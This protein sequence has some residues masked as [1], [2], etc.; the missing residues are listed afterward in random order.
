[1]R[2]TK[3]IREYIEAEVAKRLEAKYADEAAEAQRQETLHSAFCEGAAHAAE[4]AYHRYCAEHFSEVADFCD[5][6]NDNYSTPN[7]Y[8]SRAAT[9]RDR[10]V[11]TSVHSW[12]RRMRDEVMRISKDIVVTLELGGTRA[13]LEEMLNKI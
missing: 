10:N 4:E 7:F 9:I 2:V 3:N 11:I 12:R 5:L 6:G 13:E 1:M 8:S